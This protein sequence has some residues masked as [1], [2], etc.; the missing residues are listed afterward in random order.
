MGT[1][2]IAV[3]KQIGRCPLKTAR[4]PTTWKARGIAAKTSR[5]VVCLFHPMKPADV[6]RHG[7]RAAQ[8]ED[9][10]VLATEAPNIRTLE[11]GG[12]E[13]T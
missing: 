2:L 11:R 12:S 4:A 8:F 13:K 9:A 7:Y 1:D 6:S 10:I 3:H 5:S